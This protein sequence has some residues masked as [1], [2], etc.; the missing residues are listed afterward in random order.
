MKEFFLLTALLVSVSSYARDADEPR[1][2]EESVRWYLQNREAIRFVGYQGS[3]RKQHHF[4]VRIMDSW[5]F[6]QVSKRELALPEEKVFPS[7]TS[8]QM[9][10]YLVD[11]SRDFQKIEPKKEASQTSQPTSLTRHG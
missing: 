11:P 6:F 9:Y 1:P 5:T 10:Y 8:A 7:A 4:I 3:D 2:K